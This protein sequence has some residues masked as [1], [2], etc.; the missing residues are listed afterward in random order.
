MEQEVFKARILPA[1]FLPLFFAVGLLAIYVINDETPIF[2]WLLLL[3]PLLATFARLTKRLRVVNDTLHYKS[4]F[5]SKEVPLKKASKIVLKGVRS[6]DTQDD[7][8][9]KWVINVLDESG[10]IYLSFPSY[11][12]SNKTAD[13]FENAVKEVNPAIIIDL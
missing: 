5:K 13:R 10:R 1:L 8:S 12:L 9:V 4:L 11:L 6:G 2:G 3:F 7:R